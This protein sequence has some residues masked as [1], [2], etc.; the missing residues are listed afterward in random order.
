MKWLFRSRTQRM[1]GGVCGEPGKQP[2]GDPAVIRHTRGVLT[3]LSAGV[4]FPACLAAG[5]IVPKEAVP[6]GAKSQ[7]Y[8]DGRK[9]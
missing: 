2:D 5:M 1:P 8:P 3:L 9:R 6:A 7:E 4:G